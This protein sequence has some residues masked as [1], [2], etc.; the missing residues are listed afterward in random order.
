LDVTAFAYYNNTFFIAGDDGYIYK[1]DDSVEKDN[2]VDVP[3]VL[4]TKLFESPFNNVCLEKYNVSCGTEATAATLDLEI[5]DGETRIDDLHSSTAD[6]SF[7]IDIDEDDF[8]RDLNA[9]YKKFM[10]V[11]R[12]I[13]LDGQKLRINHI[14]LITRALTR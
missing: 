13:D 6:T 8:N 14:N 2:S 3:Y 11:I 9:N 1:L 4:G 10:A 5:Y 7:T 12:N